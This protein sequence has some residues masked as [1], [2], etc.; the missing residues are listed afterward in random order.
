MIAE[1]AAVR[2]DQVYVHSIE[3]NK[4]LTYRQLHELGNRM[5]QHFRDRGLKAND[6]VVMLS[7]NSVEFMAV[8][9]GVQRYGATIATANVEMNRDHMA[10]IVRAV[11]PKL[12]LIQD[13]LGLDELVRGA[14]NAECLSLGEW[15]A[16]GG[17]TGFFADLEGY[18]GDEEVPETCGPEDIAVI[19]YTSGT[20]AKPK[21]VLQPHRSVWANFDG[22]AEIVGIGPD[23]RM[24]ECRSYTWL[25]SQNMTLGAPLVGGATV[26]F[27]K[28]F[29]RSRYFDWIRDYRITIA[30]SVPTILNML[31]TEPVDIRGEDL[32]DLKFLM[33]SSAPMLP[34]RWREFEETYGIR[35]CQSYGCSE[36]GL[37]C[38]HPGTARKIGTVG[39]PLKHQTLRLLDPS[40]TEV[41]QGEPGEIT[42]SGPQIAAGY[43]RPDG[44]ILPV[45][46][47]GHRTGDLGVMDADGHIA[48]VGRLKDLI[49]RGGVN[50]SPVEIDNVLS[51][52]PEIVEGATVG[53][54]DSIYGEE[55]VAYVVP[56]AGS[57]LSPEDVIAHCGRFLAP[58]KTPKGVC[59]VD[60]LPKNDRGKLDREALARAW[61]AA[62]K[63]EA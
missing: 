21:G 11:A 23:D 43:L 54:R 48:V 30:T 34:E 24:L 44:S 18:S 15:N 42:V 33:T 20:E 6:R 4:D 32:P 41:P 28:K 55:V 22:I 5:A 63:E 47:G 46:E 3:Q 29:S 52:H 9:L 13:G 59:F 49:I 53:I 16:A 58:F 2:P 37:M 25:S 14:T 26:Y 39:L 60:D 40:G 7:E 19:F 31:M 12:V 62:E 17:S 45:P 50:I 38:S 51:R 8:F 27:A 56:R 35:V 10:E 61:P 36:A 1:Q 57:G